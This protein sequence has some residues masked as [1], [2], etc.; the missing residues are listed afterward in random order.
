MWTTAHILGILNAITLQGLVQFS[1]LVMSDSSWPHELMASLSIINSQSLLEFMSIESV[2]P[3]N[4][5]IYCRPLLLMPS[6]FPNI[7]VFVN[8][9]VLHIRCPKYSRFSFSISSSNEYSG[10]ISYRMD[11]LHLFAVQ[12][13][14]KSLLQYHSSKASILQCSGFFM[15]QLS[16]PHMTTLKVVLI[17]VYFITN[18]AEQ[19]WLYLSATEFPL[20]Q[21]LFINF[22]PLLIGIFTGTSLVAQW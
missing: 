20:L 2:M 8:E 7:R 6:I 9:S 21:S 4:H 10:L 11:W 17:G 19:F 1:H 13:T 18:K 15:V 5:L 14:L 16:H 22:V 12:E 3:F